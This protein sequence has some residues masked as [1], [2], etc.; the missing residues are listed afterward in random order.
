MEAAFSQPTNAKN[1]LKRMP[2]RH[3]LFQI[4]KAALRI[5]IVLPLSGEIPPQKIAK[6]ALANMLKWTI[7]AALI[8]KKIAEMVAA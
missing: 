1:A 3:F 2:V 8:E 5:M 6:L 7:A 4:T